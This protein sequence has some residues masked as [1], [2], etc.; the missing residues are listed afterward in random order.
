MVAATTYANETDLSRRV[1]KWENK[2]K[3]ILDNEVCCFPTT[4]EFLN[5]AHLQH[6]F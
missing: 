1:A 2:I 5:N 3:P 6:C 4:I